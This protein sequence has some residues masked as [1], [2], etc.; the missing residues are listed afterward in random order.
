MFFVLPGIAR[1]PED[2]NDLA[3]IVHKLRLH[4]IPVHTNL[5]RIYDEAGRSTLVLTSAQIERADIGRAKACCH[6]M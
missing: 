5:S 1:S 3:N 2:Q 6:L 4:D